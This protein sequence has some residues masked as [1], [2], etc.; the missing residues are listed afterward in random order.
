MVAIA[1]LL[2][3]Q[4]DS[5]YEHAMDHLEGMEANVEVSHSSHGGAETPTQALSTVGWMSD[6]FR[7]ARVAAAGAAFRVPI[8]R[9]PT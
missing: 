2:D 1:A 6:T 7:G 8:I 3:T 4:R 9:L 5:S